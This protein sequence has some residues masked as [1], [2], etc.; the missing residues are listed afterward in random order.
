MQNI[1][2]LCDQLLAEKEQL[3]F[4]QVIFGCGGLVFIL[5]LISLAD[6]IEL[7]SLQGKKAEFSAS[8]AKVKQATKEIEAS[9]SNTADPAL[10]SQVQRL[11][12][13]YTERQ[14][15]MELLAQ[16]DGAELSGFSG[17]LDDLAE[18][19][20]KGLWFKRIAIAGGGQEI[21]LAGE[22][23]KAV[24]VPRLLI[25]LAKGRGFKGHRFDQFELQ[26]NDKG[27]L[28]FLITGPQYQPGVV[29]ESTNFRAPR[30]LNEVSSR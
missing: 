12:G 5:L 11:R 10:A 19:N 28:E 7:Y 17:Y 13:E 22:T 6:G 26:N 1:D 24:S 2:L 16:P 4:K 9:F 3:P 8:W 25:E 29:A 23:L 20:I 27:V 15:L 18:H 30:I 14:H 21:T